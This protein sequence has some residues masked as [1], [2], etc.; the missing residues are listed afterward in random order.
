MLNC[1]YGFKY[2]C[3]EGELIMFND[4]LIEG[5]LLANR[6]NLNECLF[7]EDKDMSNDQ[8]INIIKDLTNKSGRQENFLLNIIHDLRG[9]LNV[10][11]SVMQCIDYGTMEIDN[12]KTLEYINI[13]K[14]NSLKMLKLVNNL[15]DTTKLENNYYVLNKKNIDIVSLIEDTVNGIDKYAKQKKIHLIFDTN[16]E[17][18]I[19]GI[20][21]E[22]IDRVIMN[23]LSNAIKYSYEDTNVYI[24]LFISKDNIKIKV[25][26]EG[27]GISKKHQEKIF[28]RFYQISNDGSRE[29]LG[30]G[31]GL[32]LVNYLIKSMSGDIVLNSK[33]G[34]GSE[35]IITLPRCIVEEKIDYCLNDIDNKKIQMLEI[36][37]SDIYNY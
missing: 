31:I 7:Y 28:S 21:P 11:L 19:V 20:D 2:S 18:C 10:I 9:H 34:E 17:E 25:R 32:D 13:V 12:K 26:D 5:D 36:E 33:E 6:R 23:L 22:A 30:S 37:F 15:I 4:G 16:K 27:P 3:Y 1:I 29:S 8:L 35:F 24:N 14:R